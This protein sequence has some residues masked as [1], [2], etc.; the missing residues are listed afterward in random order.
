MNK[1]PEDLCKIPI[2]ATCPPKGIVLDPFMGTGTSMAVA[3]AFQRK[4]IGIDISSEYI[5]LAE[6]R[7]S[8][9][10]LFEAVNV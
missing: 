10:T 4:S 1:C 8:E 5:K 3:Y 2:M 7:F 9:P 6:A